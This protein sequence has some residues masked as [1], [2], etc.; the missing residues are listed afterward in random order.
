M[1]T[2]FFLFCRRLKQLIQVNYEKLNAFMHLVLPIVNSGGKPDMAQL[3][4][5][6]YLPESIAWETNDQMIEKYKQINNDIDPSK[7]H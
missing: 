6:V 3:A 1:E 2:T 4:K 5:Q 7:K